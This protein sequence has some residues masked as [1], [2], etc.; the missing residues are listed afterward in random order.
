MKKIIA[1]VLAVSSLFFLTATKTLAEWSAGVSASVGHFKASGQ[2]SEDGEIN[3]TVSTNTLE[4]KF[5]YPSLFVE[6]NTGLVSVGLDVIPGSVETTE[7]GRT[8]YN[9]EPGQVCTGNDGCNTSVTNK[10]KV[11]IS[12]HISLYALVPI[13]ETGVF[14]KA[15][16]IRA[17]VATKESLATGSVY[18]NT[19]MK[20]GSLSLGYQY[21]FD[22]AFVRAEAGVSEYDT[23]SVTSTGGHKVTADVDGKWGRI[24]IGKSF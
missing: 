8:D 9:I 17:D 20:G 19:D 14:I 13:M 21:D 2:E 10:A 18:P 11:E 23:V 16:V 15:A 5:G 7:I 6:Y 24:S 22:A 3:K 4:G 1:I 12:Q